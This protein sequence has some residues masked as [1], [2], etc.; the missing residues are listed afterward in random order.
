MLNIEDKINAGYAS[1]FLFLNFIKIPKDNNVFIEEISNVFR[2]YKNVVSKDD[3]IKIKSKRL[4]NLLSM[5]DFI[6]KP[7]NKN[8]ISAL[9]NCAEC[10]ISIIEEKDKKLEILLKEI[11]KN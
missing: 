8:Y 7:N 6:E 9:I 4:L 3:N 5:Y 1:G 10:W 2:T 11:E